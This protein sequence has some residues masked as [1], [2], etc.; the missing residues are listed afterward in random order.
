MK[1]FE[2]RLNLSALECERFYRGQANQVVARCTDGTKIQFPATMI[3]PF[4]TENG[5]R[6]IFVLNCD[7]DGKNSRLDR[8]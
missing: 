8:G 5:V 6:G 2:F 7:D 1:R 4:L 3:R